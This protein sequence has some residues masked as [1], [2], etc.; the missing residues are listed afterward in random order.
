M[1]A[2]N[3]PLTNCSDLYEDY[4]P[5][6]D[7]FVVRRLR[8]AGFVLVGRTASPEFGIVPV[9][10]LKGYMGNIVS[11]CGAI[12]LIGSLLG[13]NRGVVPPTLN[14]DEPDPAWRGVLEQHSFPDRLRRAFGR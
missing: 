12:E 13:V 5:D 11:G 7:G 9:T 14:C 4:T 8:E 1:R 2:A 3:W 6:Y 10:A